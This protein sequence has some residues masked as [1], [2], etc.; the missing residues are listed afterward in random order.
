MH[1]PSN[2]GTLNLI[3]LLIVCFFSFF[4]NNQVIPADLMES[5]NLATAQEMVKEGNY[6]TPTLNGELR[7]EKPPLPTWIAAGIE[8]I[9]PDNLVV[10][11]CATG[12]MGTLMAFFLFLLVAKLTRHA[13]V[14]LFAAFV[15]ATCYNV[16]MMSRTATWDIYCHSLMLG[17]IYFFVCAVENRGKQWGR[18][19][20][21]GIFMGLSFLGKGP[22]SFYAL[23]LPFLIA[24]FAILRPRMRGKAVPVVLMVVACLLVACW[25]YIYIYIFHTDLAMQVL[26]KE[27][28]AWVNHNVR[29]IYYYWQFPAEA[30][31]W[32]LF[33]ITAIFS[34]FWK[35]RTR[36]SEQRRNYTFSIVWMLASLILLSVIPEKKTRYLLP[37]LIPGAM[38]IAFYFYH[39]LKGRL[40]QAEKALFKINTIVIAIIL[41][42]IPVGLY[43][44]FVRVGQLS[45]LLFGLITLISVGLAVFLIMMAFHRMGVR[46]KEVI[47][48][49]VLTMVMVT[50]LCLVPIGRM[51]IND[52][53]HG[54]KQVRE[55]AAYDLPFYYNADEELRMELV[56]D[57]NKIIRPIDAN[58][59]IHAIT[60]FVILSG[61][62]LD[63]LFPGDSTL[64]V[65]PIDTYDNNWRKRDS[66]RYN[67]ALVR[68]VGVVREAE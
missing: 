5:R 59:D 60:P 63:T 49:V 64:T 27:S 67:Q 41:L 53:R 16:I 20:L 58:S 45:W 33:W 23:L 40:S 18:F 65:D 30:G 62:P 15:L 61:K 7:L 50:G 43:L 17:A 2:P 1:K 10:Q 35:R 55:T 12:L 54:L 26:H 9:T 38:N 47:T 31:I 44:M 37:L 46:V 56:Y 13:T 34:Y 57:A 36:D 25:W 21:A 4:M 39:I 6:L 32:V 8:K 3:L 24:Y 52:E 48:G 42:A 14:G 22:V 68:H 51:F 19:L 11:R 29:P 66:R 28:T